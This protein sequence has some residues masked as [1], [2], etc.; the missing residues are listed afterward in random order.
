VLAA[1]E[2]LLQ[3]VLALSALQT[4]HNLL[5][6][7]GLSIMIMVSF[8]KGAHEEMQATQ[9]I[10]QDVSHPLVSSVFRPT[11]VTCIKD[12]LHRSKSNISKAK[13]KVSQ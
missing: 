2:G 8:V 4:E 12:T 6:G 9:S 1:L 5:G 7:L 11:R 3:T 13:G 10:M